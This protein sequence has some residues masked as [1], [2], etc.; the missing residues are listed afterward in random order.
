MEDT[1]SSLEL[2][3]VLRHS[4]RPTEKFG[5]ALEVFTPPESERPRSL[6]AIR[7]LSM[8]AID[9]VGNANYEY[10]Q[11]IAAARKAL[12]TKQNLSFEISPDIEVRRVGDKALEI[13]MGVQNK[14][15]L[16]KLLQ[17]TQ[18]Y[19]PEGVPLR[20]QVSPSY[21]LYTRVNSLA[22]IPLSFS[23]EAAEAFM[24]RYEDEGKKHLFSVLPEG[25]A[26]IDQYRQVPRSY[27]YNYKAAS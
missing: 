13:Y 27:N 16:F 8:L 2:V 4:F 21:A 26:G 12:D 5:E 6:F 10:S 24:Q 9:A 18:R 1:R 25:L 17:A 14:K 11:Q 22:P 15:E 20:D 23:D 19:I 7:S 3:H